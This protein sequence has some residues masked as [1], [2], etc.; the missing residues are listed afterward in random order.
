M[1]KK[2]YLHAIVCVLIISNA[3]AQTR[4]GRTKRPPLATTRLIG[5]TSLRKRRAS[6]SLRPETERDDVMGRRGTDMRTVGLK[7]NISPG[8]LMLAAVEV[9]VFVVI[10]LNGVAYFSGDQQ[11]TALDMEIL[12]RAVVAAGLFVFTMWTL[13][14][15]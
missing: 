1:S 8:T 15:Y 6:R 7:V 11:G 5:G 3:V 12:L 2:D 9:A 4:S 13:G 10:L 14:A